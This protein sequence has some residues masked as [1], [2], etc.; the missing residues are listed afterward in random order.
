MLSKLFSRPPSYVSK[1]ESDPSIT[2]ESVDWTNIWKVTK[3]CLVN[4]A[5]QE[6][7]FKILSYWCL[8]PDCI[9]K[10]VLHYPAE[11]I[12][13][14]KDLGMHLHVWGTSSIVHRCWTEVF[15][16]FS[17]ALGKSIASDPPVLLY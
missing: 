3:S 1:W 5:A 14:C 16:L 11:C 2:A 4:V 6:T 12:Q 13:G 8:V 15:D 7:S 17:T 9:S 10:Y